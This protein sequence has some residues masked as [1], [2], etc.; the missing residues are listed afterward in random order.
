MARLT[1][2][3]IILLTL[4]ILLLAIAGPHGV[5]HLLQL[6]RELQALELKNRA[7]DTEIVSTKNEIYSI[8]TNNDALERAAREQAGLSKPGEI[9]YILPSSSEPADSEHVSDEAVASTSL[10]E[11]GALGTGPGRTGETTV[12]QQGSPAADKLT[13][14]DGAP[15]GATPGTQ[16][17]TR[18]SGTAA[19]G[20]A[21][22]VRPAVRQRKAVPFAAASVVPAHA[23]AASR[24]PDGAQ[25]R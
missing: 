9:V 22:A 7:L 11:T 1:S 10:L 20:A 14:A 16:S 19:G 21:S 17:T 24:R 13:R 2:A 5:L 23:H 12:R 4:V 18:S 6:N 3:A 8:R 15:A 25:N